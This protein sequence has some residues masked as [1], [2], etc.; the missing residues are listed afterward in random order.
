MTKLAIVRGKFLNAYEMQAFEPLIKKYFVT[1]FGS[2]RP[3]HDS[4]AFPVVKLASPMDLPQFPLKMQIL[5]RLFT[6][7]HYLF[8]LEQQLQ[9]YDIV[10]SAETYFHYTQQCL[11]AKKKKYVKKVVATVLE[12][13]PFNNEGIRG[14]KAFKMRARNEL[15]HMIALTNRT[16]EALLLEGASENK[17][18]VI[19]HGINT[20]RF[21][22]SIDWLAEMGNKRKKKLT[23]LF[24]GRLEEY[25]GVFELLYASKHLINDKKLQKFHLN[26]L[27]VGQGSQKE[28]M[29]EMEKR[30]GIEQFVNHLSVPYTEIAHMYQLADIFV[31]PSKADRYWQEQYNTTLLEAQSAGLPIVSTLSGGIPENL[32]DAGI[33][34]QPSDVLSL[35]QAIKR[36]MLDPMQRVFYARKARERAE[37]VHDSEI[38]AKKLSDVYKKVLAS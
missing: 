3:Y 1:A 37:T 7:A 21:V 35:A 13:I 6:D 34:V 5:N 29:L 19:G 26:F 20:K 31:A 14:R 33:L 18:T 17:I 38:I 27:F 16:K 8:D 4:F 2:L 10:H 22:P 30:L 24:V 36:F 9:G 32:A 28:A 15:D 23:I 25:K 11:A 12:N